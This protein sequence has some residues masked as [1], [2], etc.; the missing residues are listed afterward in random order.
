MQQPVTVRY[1]GTADYSTIYAEMRSFTE[2]RCASTT[3]EIWLLE[4]P[5]VFTLGT[6]ADASHVLNPGLT[7]VVETDRGGQVTWHGPGQL[8]VYLLLDLRRAHIGVR[9]LVC[10]MESAII[11]TL[12]GYGIGA[13][14]REGAP[15]VYCDDAKIASVGL[16]IRR[17]RC[18]HGIAVN[19]CNN[20][21]AFNGINPCGYEGLSVTNIQT[22]GGPSSVEK[23]GNDLL[24]AILAKLELTTVVD[25]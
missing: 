2:S 7:P 21:A 6:N 24:S 16:R 14:G 12:A 11:D 23:V 17:N 19:V 3:D 9:D 1:R 5:P 4:H 13:E 20:L 8:V 15:G 22:M 25:E 18:Y 10:R